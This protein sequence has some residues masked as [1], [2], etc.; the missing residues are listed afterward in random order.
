MLDTAP[1]R[2]YYVYILYRE[3]GVTPFYVGMGKGNRWLDHERG[4]HREKSHK[5]HIIRQILTR[6]G[7]LI[8]RKVA[9]N[10]TR[11]Q[12]VAL[13]ISLI[14]A[15]KRAPH[16]PLSNLTAGGDGAVGFKYTEAMREQRRAIRAKQVDSPATRAKRAENMRRRMADPLLR[17][18]YGSAGRERMKDPLIRA[19]VSAANKGKTV[20]PETRAKIAAARRGTKHTEETRA[21]LVAAHARRKAARLAQLESPS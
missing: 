8:K 4:C 12:A 3:D 2:R 19:M 18:Q 10:F 1:D 5:A 14:A 13:E 7:T 21:K 15:I 9:E 11:E 6:G 20:S 16:G 17:E